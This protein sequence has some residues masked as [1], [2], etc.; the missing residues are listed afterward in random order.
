M[1]NFVR[2]AFVVG[3]RCFLFFFMYLMLATGATSREL[4]GFIAVVG[5]LAVFARPMM[6]IGMSYFILR[7]WEKWKLSPYQLPISFLPTAVINHFLIGVVQRL[8]GVCSG[9]LPIFMF[10]D[11]VV[12]TAIAI[13]VTTI[14]AK[15]VKCKG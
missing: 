6:F 1:E 7:R 8:T 13:V 12:T 4:N 10:L 11:V 2:I 9:G 3:I 15:V 14:W 5:T